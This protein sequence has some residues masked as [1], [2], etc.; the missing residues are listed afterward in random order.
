MS[1]TINFEMDPVRV[2]GVWYLVVR[3]YRQHVRVLSMHLTRIAGETAYDKAVADLRDGDV[4]L[5]RAPLERL[6]ENSGGYNRTRW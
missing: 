2:W 4:M 3:K 5:V 1:E 6:K